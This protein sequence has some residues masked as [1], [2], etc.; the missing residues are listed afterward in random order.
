[1]SREDRLAAAE[2][3][4]KMQEAKESAEDKMKRFDAMTSAERQAQWG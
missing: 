4:R 2:A 3:A 1:M